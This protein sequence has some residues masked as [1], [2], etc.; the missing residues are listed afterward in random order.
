MDL[1]P[2]TSATP[3]DPADSDHLHSSSAHAD[4][5]AHPPASTARKVFYGE[6]GLRAVWSLLIYLAIV[7]VCIMAVG[8]I[9]HE[10]KA[11]HDRVAAAA[12]RSSG[13]P[14]QATP[15]HNNSDPEPMLPGLIGESIFFALFFLI[16]LLMAK[17]EGRS[18]AVYGLGGVRSLSR[19]LVGAFWGLAAMGLFVAILRFTHLLVFDARL[20]HGFAILGWGFVQLLLFFL[21]GLTEEYVF[22]GY[23][24]FTLTRGMVSIGNLIS[25]KHARVIAFWIASVIT[26]A[27]FYFAH[28]G[29]GGETTF[30]LITVFLAGVLLVIALW[31]TGSLWW[32]IGF[33]TTWDWSQSFLYGVPDSG[34]LM[35]GR[36]FATHAI[37]KPLL[38]GGTDGPEG[39]LIAIPVMLL[40]IVVL[41]YTHPSPQPPLELEADL[42]FDEELN[43]PETDPLIA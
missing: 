9:R 4:P 41:L 35:Q 7:A 22:R 18:L 16:S 13:V 8:R 12:A 2:E 23:I 6:F 17:I 31:R 1:S 40:A 24:Q 27:I 42:A 36:L 26:S 33:H 14:V 29:N 28:T 20:D 11:H 34:G 5:P 3:Q 38:S 10:V 30:G 25:K 43:P 32:A 21:V 19:F 37:G 39:S 15:K